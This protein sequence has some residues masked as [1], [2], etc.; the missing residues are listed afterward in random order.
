MSL[1]KKF[2]V[3]MLRVGKNYYL[4]ASDVGTPDHFGGMESALEVISHAY[5]QAATKTNDGPTL[6]AEMI[7]KY[8]R[9]VE[10]N[11]ISF[12]TILFNPDNPDFTLAQFHEI[13]D[14]LKL[15]RCDG[16]LRKTKELYVT[17]V[18]PDL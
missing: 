13:L 14:G 16:N 7:K 6:T 15:Y 10:V 3:P 17:G 8:G 9:A 18:A 1:E 12:S 11:F 4:F 5:T 2:W